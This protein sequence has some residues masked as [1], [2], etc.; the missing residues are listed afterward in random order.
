MN[1]KRKFHPENI[2]HFLVFNTLTGWCVFKRKKTITKLFAQCFSN[3]NFYRWGLPFTCSSALWSWKQH[4]DNWSCDY[5]GLK[6]FFGEGRTNFRL[7]R[8]LNISKWEM[9]SFLLHY[10]FSS[11]LPSLHCIFKCCSWEA[12]KC[13]KRETWLSSL[14]IRTG[15]LKLEEK[16]NFA[17][18]N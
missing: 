12:F 1:W 18:S 8:I 5:P 9:F 4:W 11:G 13:A 15:T 17:L 14:N 3:V 6:T 10:K 7:L 16:I 2:K